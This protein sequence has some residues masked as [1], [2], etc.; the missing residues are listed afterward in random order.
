MVNKIKKQAIKLNVSS[1][2]KEFLFEFFTT[3][4]GK[5]G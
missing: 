2:N 1:S 5:I 3:S 4:L